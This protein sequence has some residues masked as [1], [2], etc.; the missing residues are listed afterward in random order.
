MLKIRVIVKNYL[1]NCRQIIQDFFEIY[2]YNLGLL[3]LPQG[4]LT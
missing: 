2:I 3:Q 1:P 4:F